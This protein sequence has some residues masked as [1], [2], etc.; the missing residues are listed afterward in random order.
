MNK[1]KVVA[2][3]SK[4]SQLQVKEIFNRFPEIDYDLIL[5]KSYGDHNMQI[6]LLNG[7]APDDM[8]TRGLDQLI[9]TG[10]ADIAIHSA[11]DL[12]VNLNPELEIIALYEAF[13]KTDSLVSRNHLKLNELPAGSSIGTSSPL[14]KAGLTS[15]RPDF[16]IVGI[17]GCI[18]ERVQQVRDGKIDAVIVAT[19]ALKRLGMENEIAEIL[20]FD[21][22]PMQG[23]LAITARK[24]RDDLKELFSKGSILDQIND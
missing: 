16:E 19:C 5:T 20:P 24:G 15:L 18:E 22:H 17:R 2:R 3:G 14:R 12:P 4:L 21:T 23:R 6:S 11:K 8:F 9:L 1:L 7:A 13:D 10:E